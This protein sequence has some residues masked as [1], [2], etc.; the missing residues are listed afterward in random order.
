MDLH[1][2]EIH[3]VLWGNPNPL[4]TGSFS[5]YEWRC[6]CGQTGPRLKR[7]EDAVRAAQRHAAGLLPE[8]PD[9]CA[10]ALV[11][12]LIAITVVGA[13]ARQRWMRRLG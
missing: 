1:N 7:R 8:D 9:G 6:S 2:W 5:G 10:L 4:E 11:L 13:T 3:D 12:V